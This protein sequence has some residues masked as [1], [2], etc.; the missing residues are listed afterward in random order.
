FLLRR[1]MYHLR[2]RG[3]FLTPAVIVGANQEG[4]WLAEQLLGWETS[5]LH[6]VGFADKKEPETPLLFHGLPCLG[7]VEKLGEIIEHHNIGEVILASSAFSTRDY[8][9]ETFRTYG[10]SEKVNIR[11]SSG[12]YEILTTGLTIS[13]FAY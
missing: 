3:Y 1:H 6:V 8:L 10:V 13:K 5:G 12:L 2:K 4:R 11:M 9:L 7:S